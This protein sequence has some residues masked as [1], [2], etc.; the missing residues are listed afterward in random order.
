MNN[1]ELLLFKISYKKKGIAIFFFML[2]A[3]LTF[4]VIV[5]FFVFSDFYFFS[6][7]KRSEPD[8]FTEK[9]FQSHLPIIYILSILFTLIYLTYVLNSR[10]Q[11]K[12]ISK[13]MYE[14]N[15]KKF[16]VTVSEGIFYKNKT[17]IGSEEF[18]I[19]VKKSKNKS[20]DRIQVMEGN[21][22]IGFISLNDITKAQA[23]FLFKQ[24]DAILKIP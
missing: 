9:D 10:K 1:K 23:D 15:D 6:K 3:F 20:L 19:I 17:F 11:I 14:A 5:A 21:S 12:Y 8:G 7:L 24:V 22:I 13:I 16:E 18:E 2:E 4:G